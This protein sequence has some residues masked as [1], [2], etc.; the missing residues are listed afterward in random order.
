MST[1]MT[2]QDR[3]EHWIHMQGRESAEVR[4]V[5]DVISF[6]EQTVLLDTVCGSLAI[7]GENLHI[8][9]LNVEQ[10]I[11]TMDGRIH[12]VG[13]FSTEDDDKQRKSGFFARIFR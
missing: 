12:S 13:Y 7:E 1:E 8:R 3:A 2:K 6:D 4:G 11:V 9:V 10:G 5:S